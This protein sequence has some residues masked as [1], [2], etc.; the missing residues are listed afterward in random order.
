MA[1]KTNIRS[2]MQFL[3]LIFSIPFFCLFYGCGTAE[4]GTTI[5]GTGGLQVALTGSPT[6]LAAEQNS[7]LLATVTDGSGKVVSGQTVVFS[8]IKNP[9]G[10]TITTLNGG[11]TDASGRALAV[12]TAGV[13][14]PAS[15]VQDMIQAS[16]PGSAGIVV[17]M[18]TTGTGTGTDSIF[19]L[20]ALP[21]TVS[22]GQMSVIQAQV[23]PG[24]P[25]G[26]VSNQ[27]ITFT[28]PVNNS[29]ASFINSSGA[30]V[31]TITI[32]MQLGSSVTVVSATYKAG[33]NVLGTEVEDMVQVVLGNGATS[34][35]LITR[36]ASTA[37]TGT[38]AVSIV[39]STGITP[40]TAGQ[41]SIITATVNS[42]SGSTSPP[43]AG[44]AVTFT[45]P[46]NNSGAILSAATATTDGSGKAVVIYQ[47][48][49]N[50]P[51]VSVQDTIQA[52]VGSAS[53]A[54][55]ITRTGSSPSGFG[56]IVT[57]T[58]STLAL[59]NSDS[60]IKATVTNTAG[61]V[62][63]G[64]TISFTVTGGGT[65]PFPGKATTDGSGNAGIVFTGDGISATG[66]TD[67]VEASITVNGNTYTAA[68]LVAYP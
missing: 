56:I 15:S 11:T 68:A 3:V 21:S 29:G 67:V 39:A 55:A 12:Y 35:I 40:V 32:P 50:S 66:Q 61:A 49:N 34:S 37:G 45:L 26:Q 43:A 48:G 31:S 38:Y 14:T 22:G 5:I 9:S 41:V 28:I 46:V 60:I 36:P 10:A 64:L 24:A 62:T 23:E 30:S 18:R 52:A 19:S 51:T 6:S 4:E 27:T 63:N 7:I 33:T 8:F 42:I 13:T 65:V 47:P 44:V 53:S 2:L 20:F 54:L 25:S 59:K 16:V 58:P 57:A 1:R 17:I